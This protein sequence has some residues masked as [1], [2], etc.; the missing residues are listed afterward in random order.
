MSV[1]WQYIISFRVIQLCKCYARCDWSLPMIYQSTDTWMTSCETCFLCFVQHGARFWICLWDYFGLKQV[2]FSKNVQQELLQERKMEKRGQK[3][4]FTTLKC[5]NHKKSSQ[6]LP[7]C[8]IAM[9]RLPFCKMFSPLF[10]CEQEKTLKNFSTRL[11][12][13][14]VKKKRRSRDEK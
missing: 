13:I 11:Y 7:S 9:R 3:E 8:F 5:L 10:C 2:K 1:L 14:K 6:Q 4:L 12:T